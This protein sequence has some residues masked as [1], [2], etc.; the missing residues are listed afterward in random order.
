MIAVQHLSVFF[1]QQVLFNDV[2]FMIVEKDRIGLVGKNGA[3]K[4][5]MLKIIAG[6]MKQDEGEI[7]YPKGLSFGYLPQEMEHNED[8]LIIDEAQS[9]Q[10]ELTDIQ[11]NIERI[12][13]ALAERTDY[14]SDDY[15]Q[16]INDLN[17]A[18][19]RFGLLGGYQLTENAEKVLLGLGFEQGDFKRPM[20][21]FS[22]GWKMRVELAKIL[23]QN[24]DIL[25]LDE[26]T[27]HLDIESIQWLEDFLKQHHGAI[28]MIS[29]DKAFLDAV[30]KR[31]IEISKGRIYDYKASYTKY[32]ALR[33]AEREQQSEAAKNQQKHIE[34]TEQL[35]N[36][37][38]AKK[39]KAAFA[40]SLIKKLDKLERIEVDD[41]AKGAVKIKFPP[42]P[43][44]GKVVVEAK[45]LAKHYGDLEVFGN[46][47]LLISR[48]EKVAL[49]GKN[50][51]GKTTLT[52]IIVQEENCDGE[53][54]LGHNVSIGYFAQNQAELLEKDKTVFEVIDDEAKGEIRTQ[55]RNILG[56]FLFS[57]DDIQKKVKVLSGGE[58][59]RLAMCRLLLQSY[60][61]LVLDEPTNH[62]DI[63]SK[64]VL[65]EALK[66]FD[67][68]LI[69]VSHDRDFLHG[70]TNR[71][72]EISSKRIS[73]HHDD[74][75]EFLQKKK[76]A[77]IREFEHVNKTNKREEK[78]ITENKQ[79][80]EARKQA[81]RDKRKLQNKVSK[82]EKEISRLE[83][84]LQNLQQEMAGLDYKDKE[85]SG[86][87]FGKFSETKK[88]LNQSMK[89]WED[90]LLKLEELE[91]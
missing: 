73:V 7:N 83:T 11:E 33:Q 60:N 44:S 31:T 29:H 9:A 66:K 59:T 36:K 42:A 14:E 15:M 64:E 18:N 80:Y 5:T 3:G 50:G 69:L 46:V 84:E 57:G 61:L 37:F 27:N 88:E 17:D 70:L 82:C 86:A 75:Y 39:N 91:D 76:T 2:S 28:L 41:E 20:S 38:R 78:E 35:I 4:S 24:P 19:D 49:V 21:E 1:G 43:R 56:G 53:L 26:P 71:I 79:S 72:Y 22:G 63:R 16:L 51:A 55:V 45:D 32:V 10:Q 23:L 67:G 8:A 90:A 89:E 34:H 74:I 68:T 13:T 77:S 81:D 25:L 48:G 85:A 58:K 87:M 62:L 40:Q 12:N 6:L 54:T 47:D 52:K 30:T 65:K